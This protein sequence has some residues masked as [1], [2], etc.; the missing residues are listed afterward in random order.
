[1]AEGVF[2]DV[3]VMSDNSHFHIAVLMQNTSVHSW[4]VEWQC[5]FTLPVNGNEAAFATGILQYLVYKLIC[6]I[7]LKFVFHMRSCR[8]GHRQRHTG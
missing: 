8:K 1:M 6:S 3:R 7:I 5:Y 2:S 4:R